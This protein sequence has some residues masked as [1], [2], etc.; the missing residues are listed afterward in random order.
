[1]LRNGEVILDRP[2]KEDEADAE[3]LT[4]TYLEQV[5]VNEPLRVAS[6]SRRAICQ[7]LNEP[8]TGSLYVDKTIGLPEAPYLPRVA[9][10]DDMVT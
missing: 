2:N 10:D 3:R 5:N 9:L 4:L 7:V 8:R 6:V 1:M